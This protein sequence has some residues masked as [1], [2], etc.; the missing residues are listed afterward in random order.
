[1][2]IR[3]NSEKPPQPRQRPER[4]TRES[5]AKAPRARGRGAQTAS[6]YEKAVR[7]SA[8]TR[9][10]RLEEQ[11]SSLLNQCGVD[12]L[13]RKGLSDLYYQ[14][15]GLAQRIATLETLVEN[16][17]RP[18]NASSVTDGRARTAAP[19]PQ[20]TVPP[21]W[22]GRPAPIPLIFAERDLE[23]A[24]TNY[25]NDVFES[26]DSK[27][28]RN[29][30]R[31]AAIKYAEAAGPAP[32][33]TFDENTP[34]VIW[35]QDWEESEAGW[36]VRPDGSSKHLTRS[37]AVAFVQAHRAA[38]HKEHGIDKAPAE[39]SRPRGEPYEIVAPF[40]VVEDL[41]KRRLDE[42]FGIWC[43]QCKKPTSAELAAA[44]RL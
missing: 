28:T 24:A 34:C 30:L 23:N 29:A 10:L 5:R 25:S 4:P 1:M 22:T 13:A 39:Y 7:A 40:A 19:I 32:I 44:R 8:I 21:G 26:R 9:I 17:T 35:A 42:N 2:T 33:A 43:T 6:A 27:E 20:V 41:R 15:D 31:V 37:D 38:M 18:E 12:P 11:Y 16:V 14:T 3:K 36:G